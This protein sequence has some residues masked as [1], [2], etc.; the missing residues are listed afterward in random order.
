MEPPDITIEILEDI[1]AEIR[2]TRQ[3]LSER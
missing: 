1:R 2:E 3:S